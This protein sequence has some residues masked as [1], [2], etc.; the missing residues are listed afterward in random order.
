MLKD[1]NVCQYPLANKLQSLLTG[2]KRSQGSA[3]ASEE[4]NSKA[5]EAGEQK[6]YETKRNSGSCPEK[7]LLNEIH[8]SDVFKG[9]NARRHLEDS[10][11]RSRKD[12]SRDSFYSSTASHTSQ[13]D[14]L[15]RNI[16]S[17]GRKEVPLNDSL[18]RAVS[19]YAGGIENIK[20]MTVFS[21]KIGQ[22]ELLEQMWRDGEGQ[23]DTIME[24]LLK[25][26]SPEGDATEENLLRFLDEHIE[27]EECVKCLERY[28]ANQR[29][30][31]RYKSEGN[32]SNLG[33]YTGS[34]QKK[35]SQTQLCAATS[36]TQED[37]GHVIKIT[38]KKKIKDMSILTDLAGFLKVFHV[39]KQ[40]DQT[41]KKRGFL[42]SKTDRIKEILETILYEWMWTT[43]G[44]GTV[45][46]LMSALQK[47]DDNG[48]VFF[49][50]KKYLSQN[51]PMRLSRTTSAMEMSPAQIPSKP[52]KGGHHQQYYNPIPE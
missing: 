51:I 23:M 36:I 4:E 7:V 21:M 50:A 10:N 29:K 30:T 2:S 40:I 33:D 20:L 32:L 19:Y 49:D 8:H 26:W 6:E 13:S 24:H 48:R 25:A 5:E 27:F 37:I 44:Q 3:G 18:I 35:I 14:R 47:L 52:R 15:E 34:V 31:K 16:W 42:S 41:F 28:I 39:K 11:T 38:M 46:E 45:E 17:L 22:T 1:D 9:G 12:S 43:R